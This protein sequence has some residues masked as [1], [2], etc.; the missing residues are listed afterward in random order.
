MPQTIIGLFDTVEA[1]QNAIHA[2]VY[3]GVPRGEIGFLT[4]QRTG[5]ATP[6]ASSDATAPPRAEATAGTAIGGGLGLL[7]GLSAFA[8]PGIG[9]VIGAGTLA[10][11]LGMGVIGATAGAATGGLISALNA[12]G[13]PEENADVYAESV[14]RGGTLLVV[15]TDAVLGSAVYETLRQHGAADIDVRRDALRQS[16]WERFDPTS[17]PTLDTPAPAQPAGE[18]QASSKAGTAAGMT[19]GAV[20]GAAMGSIGGPIG[21]IIGGVVGGVVGG[22]VGAAADVAGKQAEAVDETPDEEIEN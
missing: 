8:I 9:P 19:A 4:Q 13:V 10:T 1:A 5:D 16:G 22:G 12:A 3:A 20:T 6:V 11:A 7:A 17:D 2:L 14:R 18:W 21:T 15:T